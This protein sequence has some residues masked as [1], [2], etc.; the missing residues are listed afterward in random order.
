MAD[1]KDKISYFLEQVQ[2]WLPSIIEDKMKRQEQQQALDNALR[3]IIAQGEEQR[4][5]KSFG[6]GEDILKSFFDPTYFNKLNI[7]ALQ[8]L[9][10][11]FKIDP[12]LIREMG[13]QVP[14]DLNQDIEKANAVAWQAEKDRMA[15]NYPTENIGQAF[16]RYFGPAM[17]EKLASGASAVSE[18]AK[19]RALEERRLAVQEKGIPLKERE[20][21]VSEGQLKARWKELAGQIGDMTPQEA[22]KKLDKLEVERRRYQ[23]RAARTK[24]LWGAPIPEDEI[25]ARKSVIAEIEREEDEIKKKFHMKDKAAVTETGRIT[26]TN[27]ETGEK[28]YWDEKLKKWIPLK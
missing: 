3:V 4:K 25:K 20:V 11:A 26:A 19:N 16:S 8:A 24:D 2:D 12:K 23:A 21:G 28:I 7:P 27:P 1:I 18:A 15:G 5:T 22:R 14:A 10:W 9:A 17:M 13:I 6:T